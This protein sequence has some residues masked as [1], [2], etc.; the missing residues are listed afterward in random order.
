MNLEKIYLIQTITAAANNLRLNPQQIE[1]VGLLRETI[2]KSDDVG[3]E[4]LK[5]KKSTE[6][7]KLAIRLSEI[8]SFLT[9]GKVDFVKISEQFKEH[10]RYLIR[11]LN[12][13]LENVNPQVYKD[14]FNKINDGDSDIIDVELVD[15]GN[16]AS[17]VMIEGEDNGRNTINFSETIENGFS[18]DFE[19]K[20][21]KPIKELDEVLK[22]MSSRIL[23]FQELKSYC[24][25]MEENAVISRQQGFQIITKMQLI[26]ASSFNEIIEGT[27]VVNKNLIDSLRACLIVIVAIVKK[28][29]VDVNNYLSKA[30]EFNK[31]YLKKNIRV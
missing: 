27:L 10:S 17:K 11:D 12:Q 21:L 5:M 8:Y 31:K 24:S 26:I 20:I 15:R 2:T 18:L 23:D 25:I 3:A 29:D 4:F 14:S 30:E 13:F 22:K 7:S 19:R 1:V 28:K 9:H 16:F 6:L